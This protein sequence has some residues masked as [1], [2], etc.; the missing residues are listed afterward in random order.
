[1]YRA[2]S[3]QHSGFVRVSIFQFPISIHQFPP[4]PIGSS[5]AAPF[6]FCE[7]RPFFR[8]NPLQINNLTSMGSLLSEE[9]YLSQSKRLNLNGFGW[10]RF[11]LFVTGWP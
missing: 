2:H 1:M 10:V 3:K 4:L 8:R 7:N 9:A 5:E 6:I 11:L